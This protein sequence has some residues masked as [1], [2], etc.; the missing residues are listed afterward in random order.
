MIDLVAKTAGV[1]MTYSR[2]RAGVA[3]SVLV[4][5]VRRSTEWV[6]AMQTGRLLVLGRR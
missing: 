3:G 5:L 1:R 4:R 2:N 6:K